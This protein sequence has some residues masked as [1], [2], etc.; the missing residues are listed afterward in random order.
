MR[1]ADGTSSKMVKGCTYLRIQR[2]DKPERCETFKVLVVQ[3]PNNLLGRNVLEKLWSEQY[4]SLANIAQQSLQALGTESVCEAD[5]VSTKRSTNTAS[6]ATTASAVA[7]AP[8][9]PTLPPTGSGHAPDDVTARAEA[10][11]LPHGR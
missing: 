9:P 10:G 7:A 2:A 5:C 1:Q 6:P 11:E 4:V 8:S 3:G